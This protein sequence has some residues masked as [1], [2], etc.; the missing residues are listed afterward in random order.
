MTLLQSN[1]SNVNRTERIPH[2][3][4]NANEFFHLQH[5]VGGREQRKHTESLTFEFSMVPTNLSMLCVEYAKEKNALSSKS[6]CLSVL[7]MVTQ[8]I[9]AMLSLPQHQLVKPLEFQG[10]LRVVSFLLHYV[11]RCVSNRSTNTHSTDL[12]LMAEQPSQCFL[13]I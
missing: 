4:H 1:T 6:A 11:E 10:I 8:R 2:V 7:V 13:D 12:Q 3:E 9:F 5:I